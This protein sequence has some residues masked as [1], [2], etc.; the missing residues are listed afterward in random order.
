MEPEVLVRRDGRLGRITLNRPKA[1]NAL[2]FE[3]IEAIAAALDAWRN[4]DQV[5]A[6][7]L[8]GG[9]ERGFCAG[10]DVRKLYENRPPN[11]DFAFRFWRREYQLDHA[12]ATYAKPIVALLTGLV[13]GGGAG[14]GI[15]AS[16]RVVDATTRFAMP[17]TGIGLIPD[18]GASW[19]LPRCPGSAGTWLALTGE[20]IGAGDMLALGLADAAIERG[21]N[22]KL[23]E[24]LARDIEQ[25]CDPRT[26]VSA[27]LHAHG[28]PAEPRMTPFREIVDRCFSNDRVEL[29]LAALEADDSEWAA[30]TASTMRAKSP[31]MQKVALRAL[32]LGRASPDLATC[33]TREFRIVSHAA[34]GG[35]FY[36]GVRAAVIDK[37]RNPRWQPASL[38][39]V[40]EALVEPFFSPL[41]DD[42]T[43]PGQLQSRTAP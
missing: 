17:E 31:L 41:A 6:V 21:D 10:G 9:G 43:L 29:I 12:I 4:D 19:F 24:A 16:H 35:E 20:Q 13:M 7:I 3:M 30:K 28:H 11:S 18:I 26:A 42:L 32:G 27:A 22:G 15:H 37:D 1:I 33:L 36:E 8:E 38:A 5:C 23:V 2:T 39:E 34:L 14:L 40:T 25:G